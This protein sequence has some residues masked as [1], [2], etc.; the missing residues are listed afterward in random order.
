MFSDFLRKRDYALVV[1]GVSF[2]IM[3]VYFSLR[4]PEYMS[5]I[6]YALRT[7][8]GERLADRFGIPMLICAFLALASS[9]GSTACISRAT[10]SLG[11]NLRKAQ[12]IK[13]QK[14]SAQDT[15]HF[16]PSSLVTRS[17]NDVYQLQ[18]F[19]SMGLVTLASS[20]LLAIWALYKISAGAIEWTIAMGFACLTVLAIISI[21]MFVTRKYFKQIQWLTDDINNEVNNEL[22]GIRIIHS[23]E[24]EEY[25]HKRLV[26]TS[27]KLLDN[28]LKAFRNMAIMYPS[29]GS[30]VNFLTIAAYWI[31]MGLVSSTNSESAQII[32]FSEM[33]V[34]ASYAQFVLSSFM[35]LT[36]IARDMPRAL[37]CYNRIKEVIETEPS[38][39]NGDETKGNP[40][41]TGE[42]RFDHVSFTYPG[43]ET[44]A[45]KDVSFSLKRGELLAIVGPSG[46]GKT[47][48]L[49]LI[50]R[51]YDVDDGAIYVNGIDVRK[52]DQETLH[53]MMG[54]VPQTS[55]IFP[56]TVRE[57][58]DLVNGD[59]DDNDPEIWKALDLAQATEFVQKRGG[60]DSD[61]FESGKNLSGGQKQRLSIARAV[62]RKSE[63]YILDDVFSALD[64]ITEKKVRNG[65]NEVLKKSTTLISSQKMNVVAG[66]DN[67][68]VLDEGRIV[69]QGNHETLLNSCPI[70][71][72]ISNNQMEGIS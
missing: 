50:T 22:T 69:G 49:N 8:D 54:F 33:I 12:F 46:S 58:V 42:I 28:N 27:G 53:A 66:A 24:A 52:W 59:N 19:L 13:V 2:I 47:T 63:F 36:N 56:G 38:I 34:F 67:I 10:M 72:E 45:L 16:S 68:L 44:P 3:Q 4:I 43:F 31:G 26:D 39:K 18:K 15:A 55:I 48:I 64:Q 61:T 9:F 11:I 5:N 21:G 20:P 30:V 25:H 23:Y 41:C 62:Y 71:A 1:L 17:T 7:E 51:I 60:L 70:Y 35:R 40:D 37:V 57:N 32:L 29:A 14:F 65:L 6:T